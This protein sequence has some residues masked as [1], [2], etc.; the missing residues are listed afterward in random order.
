MNSFGQDILPETA[1]YSTR[2]KDNVWGCVGSAENSGDQVSTV[3]DQGGD[4]SDEI[5]LGPREEDH[6]VPRRGDFLS[7]FP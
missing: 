2:Q 7:A 3:H 6:I 1:V 5:E 4:S